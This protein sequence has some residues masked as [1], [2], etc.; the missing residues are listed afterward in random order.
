MERTFGA[1]PPVLVIAFICVLPSWA[2]AGDQLWGQEQ[3]ELCEW[4]LDYLSCVQ[5]HNLF[6]AKFY[7]S[8]SEELQVAHVLLH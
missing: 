4:Y 2:E 1:L 8:H 7:R 6:H 3:A 5:L